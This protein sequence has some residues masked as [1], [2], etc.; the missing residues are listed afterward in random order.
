M[1]IQVVTQVFAKLRAKLCKNNHHAIF[2]HIN[3]KNVQK[4]DTNF[5]TTVHSFSVQKKFNTII[6]Y[7][8]FLDVQLFHP[9][10]FLGVQLFPDIPGYSWIFLGVQ[11][12]LDQEK[13]RRKSSNFGFVGL[14]LLVYFL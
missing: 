14:Y 4:T 12:F 11:L 6:P 1:C 2:Q 10:K 7:G 13:R 9:W 8:V 3:K 5:T